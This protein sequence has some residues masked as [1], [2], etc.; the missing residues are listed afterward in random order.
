MVKHFSGDGS[1]QIGELSEATGISR[2][3]LRFYEKRGLLTARRGANGYRDYAPEAVDWLRYIRT[4]QQ[5]GFTLKEIE[6]DLPL[7]AAPDASAA[8][9]R[10]ALQAKVDEIDRRMAG[11]AALREALLRRLDD[12]M[13]A[14]PLRGDV[15]P[16]RG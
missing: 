11:L 4:A 10:A 2:D 13:A 7:L 1:M 15:P 8:R 14:C 12:G 6:A 9:L 3:T 16:A 5:L